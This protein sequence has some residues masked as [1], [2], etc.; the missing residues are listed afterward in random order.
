MNQL[1]SALDGVDK[2]KIN[3]AYVGAIVERIFG[4]SSDALELSKSYNDNKQA[5]YA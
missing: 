1:I 5:W 4:G 2:E 3:S